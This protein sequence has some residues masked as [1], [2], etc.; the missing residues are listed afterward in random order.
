[1]SYPAPAT[2]PP[3]PIFGYIYTM[4]VFSEPA[5]SGNERPWS[6][7]VQFTGVRSDEFGPGVASEVADGLAGYIAQRI[8]EVDYADYQP[9]DGPPPFYVNRAARVAVSRNHAV[10]PGRS[11]Q[12]ILLLDIG[13]RPEQQAPP[14]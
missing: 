9:D 12:P 3:A 1:M 4:Q 11:P 13:P 6:F 5:R 7:E 2:P 10:V 8:F 14:K